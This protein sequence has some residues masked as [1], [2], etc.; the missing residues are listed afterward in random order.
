MNNCQMIRFA[1][2]LPI[3]L[4]LSALQSMERKNKSSVFMDYMGIRTDR[5][6]MVLNEH[7]ILKNLM[8]IFVILGLFSYMVEYGINPDTGT[9]RNMIIS[10]I[11]YFVLALSFVSSVIMIKEFSPYANVRK[12]GTI[13]KMMKETHTEKS[14]E[15]IGI[16]SLA[17]GKT[18]EVSDEEAY[19][20]D[21]DMILDA[22]SPEGQEFLEFINS[23]RSAVI[24][25]ITH[26]ISTMAG[27]V[28][29]ILIVI[30]GLLA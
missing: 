8:D 4:L 7:H 16:G 28:I 2:V 21:T 14:G 25:W 6:T 1:I 23:Q 12:F 30:T 18:K 19:T 24:V 3:L 13:L 11:G 29:A 22:D 10:E 15:E 5:E 17:M 20:E 26:L 27:F 9:Y